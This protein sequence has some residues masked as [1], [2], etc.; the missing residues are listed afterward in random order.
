LLALIGTVT[1]L[2]VSGPPASAEPILHHIHGLAFTP[3]GKALVVPAHIGLAIYRDGHWSLAQGPAHDFMGFSVAKNAIYTS[4]HPAPGSPLRNPLGLMKSTDGGKTWR[5][6][7]LYGEADFHDIAVG[8]HTNVVY[9]LISGANSRMPEAGV[10]Y[11]MDEGKTW[12]RSEL[13]GIISPI[14]GIAAHPSAPGTVAMG[15]F[16]GLHLSRNFGQWFRRHG[17]AITVTA[18]LFELDGKH[19]LFAS[20]GANALA[21]VALDGGSN[22]SIGLP[23]L[24]SDVV[25]YIAQSP[26]KPAELAIATRRKNVFLSR[27][28]GKNWRQI[29]R[30]GGGL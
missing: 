27:D 11:T 30:E 13:G 4:G 22:R 24:A 14:T 10:Y 28:A 6:L 25:T 17:P 15:T 8:H 7:S 5:Q 18:V 16:G 20:E 23:V 21:R 19:M 2:A 26:T 3:D 1:A 29:A 9:V 12:K